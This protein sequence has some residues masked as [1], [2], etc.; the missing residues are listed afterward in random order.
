MRTVERREV[1]DG[2][3][4]VEERPAPRPAPEPTRPLQMRLFPELKVGPRV[5]PARR[6]RIA[7][8]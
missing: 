6:G 1:E 2:A 7:Y 5:D 3:R 4:P 8:L